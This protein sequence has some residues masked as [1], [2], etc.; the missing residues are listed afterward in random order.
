MAKLFNRAKMT[1][2]TTGSGTVT[3]SAAA[4]G[5]Q[6]FADAGVS[7]GDVVQ[8]LI[9][10]GSAWEIGT[11]TYSSTGTSLTRTPSESSD[12]GT[13]IT[14]GGAAN[15][16]ITAVADDLNRLQHEGSDKVTVSSTG[17]SVTGALTTSGD[18]T[19]NGE[20]AADLSFGDSTK[21]KF[22]AGDDL[23]I[24]HDG[25][26]SYIH[27]AGTGRL[28]LKSSSQIDMLNASG[29]A[30]LANF[31]DGGAAKLYHNNSNKFETTSTGV[32]ITGTLT[33]DGLTVDGNATITGNTG[34][35]NFG[36]T[37]RND[38]GAG[39]GVKIRGGNNTA[40]VD[41]LVVTKE[42][43]DSYVLK[44]N[45]TGDISF[46]EDTGTTA[47]FFWDASA[48][49]LTIADA[50]K[51]YDDG[52]AGVVAAETGHDLELRARSGQNVQIVSGGSEAMRIDSSG[53]LLVGTT[54]SLIWN[55]AATDNSK[56]GVVIEPKS[57]QISR[58]QDTQA[59]FN[60]QGNDGTNLVFAKDGTV[61]GSI[62][63]ANGGDLY[64]G[65]DDTTLLFAGGSDAILPR[66]TAGGSRDAAINLGLS[67]HRFKDLY[68]SGIAYASY[69]G[70]SSDTDTSIAF[71]TANTIRLSTGG[72]ERMRID[73]SG[74][75]GIGTT[76]PSRLLHLKADDS[77]LLQLQVGNTTGNCQILF[78][79][80]GST[81]VGKVLYNHSTNNMSFETNGAEDM[82]L[83]SGGDLHVD[84]NVI[85]Y[86][87]TTS[88]PRLKENIQPVTDGLGKVMQLN[89]Y[90]FDYKADGVSSAGILS[91]EVAKVLPSAVKQS[92]L[93]LKLGDDNEI[94]YDIVQYDQLTALLI[95]AIKE[96]KAEIE[97]LK[98][99]ASN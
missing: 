50:V 27:D 93:G 79:D 5:F 97:E 22:G 48:E 87:T 10:E 54:D 23:Q 69:V 70:S 41:S 28:R 52:T 18:L 43:N 16:A 53:N 96:L 82:R 59:L 45:S 36:V 21:A 13:A 57:L 34:A 65:N 64:I 67:S 74:N 95:E 62:G 46:Y 92:K 37:L 63:T 83:T 94:E 51:F 20:V 25:S 90:T 60:R 56:E 42:S 49:D 7:N 29:S 66:G 80:S 76:S 88:D 30:T 32:D 78:G 89:G 3:L 11:G 24:Y 12:G 31:I 19:V 38:D 35:G 1:T 99:G 15:V 61:V 6:S 4:G 68:L 81:T 33:S 73:S 72:T 75:V 85:A 40:S 77:C 26:H 84:G 98:N 47:K 14:L 55:E 8:Y 91:T 39:H 2:S 86:S 17:A 58:Y 44:A 9:E 71:D